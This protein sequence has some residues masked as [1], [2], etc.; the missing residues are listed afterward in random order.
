MAPFTSLF[1]L[2]TE[3]LTMNSYFEAQKH[4]IISYSYKYDNRYDIYELNI[5]YIG[6]L[7]N[8]SVTRHRDISSKAAEKKFKKWVNN[9]I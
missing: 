7:L 9:W 5:E 4:R 8:S 3:L 1:I 2:I 6:V